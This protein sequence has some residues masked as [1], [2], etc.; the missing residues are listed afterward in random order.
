MMGRLFRWFPSD[1]HFL[2]V[3]APYMTAPRS[4]FCVRTHARGKSTYSLK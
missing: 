3:V 4:V 1:C 2:L